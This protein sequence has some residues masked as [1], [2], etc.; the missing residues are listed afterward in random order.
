[1][2]S[3]PPAFILSQDQTLIISVCDSDELA[4]IL[5]SS[6]YVV[7]YITLNVENF[8]KFSGLFHCLII[9]VLVLFAVPIHQRQLNQ[10]IIRYYLCQHLFYYFFK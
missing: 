9:K 10:Y 4:L 6:V 7:V 8:K 1:M 3:T 2:L 5:S